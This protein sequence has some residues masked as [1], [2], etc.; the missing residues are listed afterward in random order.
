[1]EAAALWLTLRLATLATGILVICGLPCTYW[2]ARNPGRFSAV[3]ESLLTLPMVLPPT[4]LGF[5]LLLLFAP[6]GLAFSFT[7]LLAASV[8][9]G[10]PFAWQPLMQAFRA[11][12]PELLEISGSL[13]ENKFFTFY[14]V[15]LPLAKYGVFTAASM[16]FAHTVG[17]FGVVLLIGGNIPGITRTLSIALFDRVES[18]DYA[19][20]HRIAGTLLAFSASVLLCGQYWRKT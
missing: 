8:I 3:L 9:S 12:D 19:S 7:G 15:G 1:M 17:E 14:R 2:L 20:A 13:G 10:L 5:Y 4:V 18:L 6:F 11:V 16:A